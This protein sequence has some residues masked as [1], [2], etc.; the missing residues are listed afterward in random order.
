MTAPKL[1]LPARRLPW[2]EAAFWLALAACFF[3]LPERLALLGQMLALGLFA[4]SL[5]LALGYA[6]ILTVGHAAF[7]GAGAYAAGLLA[8]HGWGDP[9]LGLGAALAAGALLGCA[10]SYLMVRGADLTRLMVSIALCALL[11]ELVNRLSS[12]TGGSDGLQGMEVQP[13]LGRFAFDLYGRTAFVYTY[14][15]VLALFL[16]VRRVLR[17][18]FGLA[19]RGIRDNP[20]RMQALGAP[21]QARLRLAY[22][23]SAAVAGAA[24]ALMAQGTQFVGLDAIGFERSAEV[25]IILVLGGAGRLY[26]GLAGATVYMLARDGFAGMDPQYWTFWLGIFLI[27]AALLGRGGIMGLLSRLVRVKEEAP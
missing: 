20:R 8:K 5:D 17:S 1:T 13:V 16:L 6:G 14:C 27:A 11:A 10:T 24:G 19:L 22:G 7:F 4:L 3:V 15:V 9:L 2:L 21:V 23:F 26:G 18:P 25:L 12:I